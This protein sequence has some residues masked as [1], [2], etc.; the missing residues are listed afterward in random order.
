MQE[1]PSIPNVSSQVPVQAV[2]PQ[3]A[4]IKKEFSA[5]EAIKFGFNFFKA[6]I[7]TFTELGIT[8][9]LLFILGGIIGFLLK[10]TNITT[11]I[12]I[13]I[14][15]L[16]VSIYLQ[17]VVQIGFTKIILELYDGRSLTL[18]YLYSLYP[19]TLRY[20]GASILY[21]LMSLIGY[22]LL[23][24]PGIIW[25]IKFGFY[26]YLIVDK[27][28]GLI[29]SLKKSSALTQGVKMNLFLFYILL[30]LLNTVGLLALVIGLIG[31]L[32]WGIGLLVSI[33]TTIMATVYVYRKLLSQTPN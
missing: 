30:F 13:N 15:W 27:N 31:L 7:G 33:P 18:S 11:N 3:P 2:I 29:D 23:I 20:I 22:V 21:G 24:I 10:K 4:G 6:N 12:T 1:I 16:L 9:L 25:S 14:I 26:S 8:L 17:T 19:L 28:A 5:G 32:V